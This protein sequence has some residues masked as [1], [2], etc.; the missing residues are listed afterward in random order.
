MASKLNWE[1]AAQRSRMYEAMSYSERIELADERWFE[2]QEA[3]DAERQARQEER[4]RREAGAP[5]SKKQRAALE[6]VARSMG[7]SI[8]ATPE[9]SLSKLFGFLPED[10][11]R[12]RTDVD[13]LR[14]RRLLALN[15]GH[16]VTAI[17]KAGRLDG[18]I[19]ARQLPSP[20]K[21]A[22][23]KRRTGPPPPTSTK[24]AMKEEAKRTGRSVHEVA[25]VVPGGP[26]SGSSP[27]G[28]RPPAIASSGA[29]RPPKS[30]VGTAAQRPMGSTRAGAS[31]ADTSKGA[32]KAERDRKAAAAR[33]IS[34]DQLRAVRR[35][36][37][38][39]DRQ[40]AAEA[41]TLGI[42]TKELRRR[43]GSSA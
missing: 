27:G 39:V 14:K 28:G 1:R 13:T 18:P 41:K 3:R 32:A 7:I 9:S 23:K 36:A 8:A 15:H 35:A 24:E 43:R 16:S 11:R 12:L 22:T 10:A 30:R 29:G 6:N 26:G 21:R 33:G 38:Q 2:R 17:L 34:V 42:S 31:E 40:M 20:P 25:G 19:S 4:E 5:L 37:A